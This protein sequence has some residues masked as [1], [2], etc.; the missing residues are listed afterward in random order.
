MIG[1]VFLCLIALIVLAVPIGV[2]LGMLG[3]MTDQLFS[4]V[5]M[6]EAMAN[7]LPTQAICVSVKARPS[8]PI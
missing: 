2:A 6:T 8:F 4:L 3:L 1:V 7:A 5:P